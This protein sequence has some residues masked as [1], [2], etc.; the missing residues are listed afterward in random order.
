M[1]LE[2]FDSM[3]VKAVLGLSLI[4]HFLFFHQ[5]WSVL[6]LKSCFH[7]SNLLRIFVAEQM[8]T[9]FG[10]ILNLRQVLFRFI[11]AY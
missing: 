1:L 4:I 11:C 8:E 2:V 6:F 5:I 7:R 9:A 10:V 3:T